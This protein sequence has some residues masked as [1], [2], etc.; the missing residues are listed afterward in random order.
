MA[1]AT[2]EDEYASGRPATSIVPRPNKAQPGIDSTNK[3]NPPSSAVLPPAR[4]PRFE[5]E[6]TTQITH[7]M[8]AKTE[9]PPKPIIGTALP[10]K[11]TSP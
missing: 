9:P 5:H 6:T 10:N 11:L 3:I 4:I 8:V 1:N 2:H 7:P